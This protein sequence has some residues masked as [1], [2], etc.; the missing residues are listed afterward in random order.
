MHSVVKPTLP[1]Q[2]FPL[3]RTN[4]FNTIFTYSKT[5]R[6]ETH[7]IRRI[8]PD[9]S[10]LRGVFTTSQSLQVEGRVRYQLMQG[11]DCIHYQ[12]GQ[13]VTCLH[14]QLMQAKE[15]LHNQVVQAGGRVHRQLM[16]AGGH[17]YSQLL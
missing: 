2:T 14:N 10:L 17:I 3:Y 5:V 12:L 13:T 15:R 7:F 16:Q 9:Q 1:N 4:F 11:D 6:D 8:S